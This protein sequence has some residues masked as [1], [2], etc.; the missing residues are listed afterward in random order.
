MSDDLRDRIR[1][2]VLTQT[3]GSVVDDD[4]DLFASGLVNSLFAVQLVLWLE[5]TFGLRVESQELVL[6]T[7]ATIDSIGDFVAGKQAGAAVPDGS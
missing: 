7:F 3:P 6:T 4:D 2:F 1:A 5:Q